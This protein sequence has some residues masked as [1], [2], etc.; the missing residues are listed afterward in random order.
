VVYIYTPGTIVSDG[1][2]Y[3]LYIPAISQSYKYSPTTLAGAQAEYVIQATQL[4][5][6]TIVLSPVLPSLSLPA[7][8]QE[9]GLAT[10]S[11]VVVVGIWSAANQN[12]TV[13][14]QTIPVA[15]IAT[16]VAYT[17]S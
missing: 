13:A 6:K 8:G 17:I 1:T 7:D 10:T 16:L 9:I 4:L 5:A 2:F 15:N 3:N 12:V 14:A 11:G